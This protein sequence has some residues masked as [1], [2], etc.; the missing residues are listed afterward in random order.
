MKK[1]SECKECQK[2]LALILVALSAVGV[3]LSAR[4]IVKFVKS[5]NQK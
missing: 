1:L 3:V 5:K 2:R 4:E